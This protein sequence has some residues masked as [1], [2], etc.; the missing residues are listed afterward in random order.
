MSSFVPSLLMVFAMTP[1]SVGVG[2]ILGNCL[3]WLVAPARRAFDAEARGYP[4]TEFRSAM[5][6]L[7]EL[8]AVTL[9]I[10][11]VV[12]IVSAYFLTSLK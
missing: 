3:A 11:V 8:T 7:F 2:L 5:R 6:G 10:G 4:G 12:A 9:P 1:G